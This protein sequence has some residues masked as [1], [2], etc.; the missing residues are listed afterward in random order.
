M[1]ITVIKQT[2]AMSRDET[3]IEKSQKT[4]SVSFVFDESWDGFTKT[5][6]FQAGSVS[7]SVALVDDKCT[8]P[9]KCLENAGVILKVLVEGVKD[10]EERSTP[11]CLT[12]RILYETTIDVPNGSSH[13]CPTTPTEPTGEVGRLCNDFAG[14]LEEYPE[15]D[16]KGKSLSEVMGEVCDDVGLTATD[17]EVMAALNDVW[18]SGEEP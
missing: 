15:E 3:L 14:V 5:A 9:A 10:G 1:E 18:G 11:W 16:L 13:Q 7:S 8:I 17:A 6:H 12:S 2:I 4:Y